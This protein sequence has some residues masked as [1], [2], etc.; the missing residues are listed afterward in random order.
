MRKR[1]TGNVRLKFA[2]DPNRCIGRRRVEIETERKGLF[3]GHAN[4]PLPLNG[5]AINPQEDGKFVPEDSEGVHF[6][7]K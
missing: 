7:R 6:D 3:L 1:L 5:V 2:K 4:R